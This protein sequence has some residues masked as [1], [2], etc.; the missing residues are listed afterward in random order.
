[1]VDSFLSR[2]S[3]RDQCLEAAGT[4]RATLRN[5]SKF[6]TAGNMHQNR[7]KG[8]ENVSKCWSAEPFLSV[9]FTVFMFFVSKCLSEILETKTVS[10]CLSGTIHMCICMC[11]YIYIYVRIYIYMYICVCVFVCAL[12]SIAAVACQPGRMIFHPE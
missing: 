9:E 2:G 6:L 3:A 7:H 4:S 12:Q 10:K 8:E 1:M 5:V 11:T